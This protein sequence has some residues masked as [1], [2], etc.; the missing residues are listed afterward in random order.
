MATL[1]E[2]VWDSLLMVSHSSSESWICKSR[3]HASA[4][5]PFLGEP[6]AEKDLYKSDTT[7]LLVDAEMHKDSK[8]VSERLCKARVRESLRK[9]LT[10][11]YVHCGKGLVF[12][13]VGIDS[14]SRENKITF[15]FL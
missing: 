14:L 1:H 5:L 6:V 9:C 4:A 2:D 12:G 13:K 11:K 10:W 8:D 15:I 7:C 3:S